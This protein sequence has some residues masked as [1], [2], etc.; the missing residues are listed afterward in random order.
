MIMKH[1]FLVLLIMALAFTQSSLAQSVLKGKVVDENDGSPLIGAT[2]VVKGT[3]NGTATNLDGTFSLDAPTGDVAIKVSYVGYIPK[4]FEYNLSEGEERDM[5]AVALKANSIGLDEVKVVA[6][7]A[8]DRQTPVAVSK[9]QPVQI[10]EKMGTQELPELMKSTPSVY[11]TKEG[12]G[13]GDSRINIRGFSQQNIAVLINGVPV[14]DMENGSVYWSNWANLADVTKTIQVQRGLGASRLAIS[15][16]G[17]TMNIITQSTDAEP[18]GTVY[19]SFGNDNYSKTSFSVSTGLLDN[20]WAVTMQGSKS[21]G[22]GFVNATNFES[23]SYF[24]NVSKRINENHRLSLTGFGAPQW[25][26]RR[27]SPH[28]INVYREED[29]GIKYNSDY[30]YLNGE[31]YNTAY[32]YNEYHKPQFY[33]NHYWKINENSSLHTST[34]ASFGRGGGRRANGPND[35]WLEFDYPSGEPYAETRLNAQGLIDYQ[36]ILEDNA[37]SDVGSQA[38]MTMAKNEHDWYGILSTY[39]TKYANI[40]ITAGFDGRYYK[41]YHYTELTDLLGGDYFLDD[42]NINRDPAKPLQEGAKISYYNLGEVLREGVF[43]QGE[44]VTE[45]YSAFLSGTFS[46]KSYRRVDYFQYEPGNQTSEWTNFLTYSAKGGFNYNLSEQHN[47]FVN[48]GYFTRAPFFSNIFKNYTNEINNDAK[49]QK[50]LSTEVGYGFRSSRLKVD[51]TGYR[52]VWMDKTLT[53]TIGQEFANITGLNAV[54]MGLELEATFKPTKKLSI[55]AMGSMGDYKW[56]K[57]VIADIY[58]DEQNYVGTV[59]V[60]AKDVRR[61]NTALTTAYLGASY[62]VLPD[63]KVGADMYYAADIFAEFDVENRTTPASEGVD[64]W[65]MPNYTL[66]NANFRYDFT[67]G[68]FDATLT[69]NVDNLLD[70]EYISDAKDGEGHSAQ[71]ASVWY[72]WGRTWN[73]GLKFR[74]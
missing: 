17:G 10:E 20:G 43:L 71:N 53:R 40:N 29:A 21:N 1:R 59:S 37:S 56:D 52:T 70:T 69:G 11:A 19:Q 28:R 65:K 48:G 32:A 3:S 51:L 7:F 2:V 14:N 24:F 55:D 54:H 42:A 57:N 68:G 60:F 23:Y 18:G 39:N 44:Y 49:L 27:S 38:V 35:R 8:R 73:L 66:V 5:G 72:G 67:L 63:F 64:S 9:V 22:N 26:N 6:N 31:I 30:G 12:G 33:L 4:T 50:I 25:H 41:G 13:F 74:F 34:Y 45:D 61:G 58:D 62:W 15:S 36:G 47:V 16:V 46:N